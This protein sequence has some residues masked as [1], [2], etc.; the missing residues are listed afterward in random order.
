MDYCS[1]CRR[2]LNGALVCPGCGAYAP[3]IA[4]SAVGGHTVPG[5]ATSAAP[6][7]GFDAA[8]GTAVR[9]G[10]ESEPE[11]REEKGGP[12]EEENGPGPGTDGPDPVPGSGF[13]I[14]AP[15][16]RAARRRQV[17]R[18][19]K[20]QRRALVATAVA[21]VGGGLALSSVDRGSDDRARAATAPEV[22]GMGGADGPADRDGG[23]APSVSPPDTQRSQDRPAQQAPDDDTHRQPTGAASDARPDGATATATSPSRA[24]PPSDGS[25]PQAGSDTDGSGSATATRPTTPPADSSPGDSSGNGNDDNSGGGSGGS[26]SRSGSQPA[27]PPPSAPTPESPGS[28]GSGSDTDTDT[29]AG[30]C[31]LVICLG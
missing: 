12:G 19:K 23:P 21:F 14:S 7:A 24:T 20:T 18:W 4:P 15:T 25:G 30:L 26:G 28:S 9:T 31:L 3:D 13:A 11:P 2:H 29:D 27:A 8:A 16:G 6:A 22:S 1:T 10:A 5:A 17:A